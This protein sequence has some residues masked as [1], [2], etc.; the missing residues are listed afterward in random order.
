MM[1]GDAINGLRVTHAR[2]EAQYA[3]SSYAIAQWVEVDKQ[4]KL[5]VA[6]AL[7]SMG[8]KHATDRETHLLI[9]TVFANVARIPNQ[10]LS[11][12]ETAF[13]AR[14]RVLLQLDEEEF[15]GITCVAV[16]ISDMQ[17]C[18]ASVGDCHVLLARGDIV[19]RISTV[20]SIHNH[21][22]KIGYISE[23]EYRRC[24]GDCVGHDKVTAALGA[25]ENLEVD[26]SIWLHGNQNDPNAHPEHQLALRQGDRILVLT[27][28][29][30][31]WVIF[32]DEAERWCLDAFI[33]HPD[34]SEAIEVFFA[35]KRKYEHHPAFSIM[36]VDVL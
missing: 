19:R 9:E 6:V 30:L 35:D 7:W 20:H 8:Q 15:V 27:P 4:P 12:F 33:N 34:L 11:A 5:L 13:N 2:F 24:N 10:P 32:P 22:L 18:L 28:H 1:N 31:P 14:N 17:L 21:L 25:D 3:K 26:T 23:L 16:A 36:V 29:G